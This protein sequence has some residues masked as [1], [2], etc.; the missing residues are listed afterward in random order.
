MY[1]CSINNIGIDDRTFSYIVCAVCITYIY[2]YIHKH[3]C[4]C[5]ILE[6][7]ATNINLE[8]QAFFIVFA[9]M[10][11]HIPQLFKST[12]IITRNSNTAKY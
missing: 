3:L 8:S 4:T 5:Y 2:I 6:C 12:I 7:I 1:L 11:C 9:I 10:F